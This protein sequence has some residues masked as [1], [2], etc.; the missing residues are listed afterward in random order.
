[1]TAH[2]PPT[3]RRIRRRDLLTLL[4]IRNVAILHSQPPFQ[5]KPLMEKEFLLYRQ[6]R[7]NEKVAIISCSL[8]MNALRS[9]NPTP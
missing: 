2:Q 6:V 8:L 1:M 3:A 5:S 9:R 7:S 4:R